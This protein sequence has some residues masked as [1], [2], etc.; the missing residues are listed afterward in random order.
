MALLGSLIIAGLVG[1]LC[2]CITLGVFERPGD[3]PADEESHGDRPHLP[4]PLTNEGR[5]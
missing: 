3:D 5:N 2:T 1:A 4:P